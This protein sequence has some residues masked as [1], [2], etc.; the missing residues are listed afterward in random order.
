MDLNSEVSWWGAGGPLW[1][2]KWSWVFAPTEKRP[3][4]LPEVYSWKPNISVDSS[5]AWSWPAG[6]LVG[7]HPQLSGPSV[8][9]WRQKAVVTVKAD[10]PGSLPH[11]SPDVCLMKTTL[12]LYIPQPEERKWSKSYCTPWSTGASVNTQHTSGLTPS[13]QRT[14]HASCPYYGTE[15]ASNGRL[16]GYSGVFFS[17]KEQEQWG[18]FGKRTVA[19]IT[20]HS[21]PGLRSSSFSK[22]PSVWQISALS[23]G[24]EAAPWCSPLVYHV[25]LLGDAAHT[26]QEFL[27]RWTSAKIHHTP[28]PER[29]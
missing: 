24:Q 19:Q 9:V 2:G 5:M 25:S 8:P 22:P 4:P 6:L 26:R 23:P 3:L 27:Q 1:Y 10:A 13:R 11:F 14:L 21:M 18:T 15:T 17:F 12:C 7:H 29:A 20:T 16:I 28:W